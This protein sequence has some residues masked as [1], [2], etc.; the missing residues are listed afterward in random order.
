LFGLLE[1][2]NVTGFTVFKDNIIK[3]DFTGFSNL[4]QQFA[5]MKEKSI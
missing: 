2:P 5:F 3:V 4:F 1:N